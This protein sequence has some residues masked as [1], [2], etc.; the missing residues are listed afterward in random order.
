MLRNMTTIFLRNRDNF[1]ML[2]RI[3]SKVVEPS[4]CGIGG[5]FEEYELNDPK[6]CVIRELFEETGI[7]ELDI[8]N[9]KLR[10]MTIRLKNKEIRQNYYYFADLL[11][12]DID[13]AY[14]SEGQLKWLEKDAILNYDMPYTAKE[15]LKHYLKTD[16]TSNE[17]Y[18]GIAN[19]QGINFEKLR[20]F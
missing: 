13:L 19:E 15:C 3:G 12:D 4:W 2:F 16:F 5:H 20:E 14:C 8:E 9:L 1:L 18:V 6:S 17:I 7:T 11:S 10:Y